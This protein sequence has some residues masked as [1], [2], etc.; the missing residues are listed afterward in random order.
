MQESYGVLLRFGTCAEKPGYPFVVHYRGDKQVDLVCDG[1]RGTSRY[2]E[3][4]EDLPPVPS[5]AAG[6]G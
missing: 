2:I 6:A 3:C 5:V 4:L 1:T